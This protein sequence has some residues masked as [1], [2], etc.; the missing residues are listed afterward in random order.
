MRKAVLSLLLFASPVAAQFGPKQTLFRDRVQSWAGTLDVHGVGSGTV[1]GPGGSTI[2]YTTDQHVSGT[3]GPLV[4]NTLLMDWEGPLDGTITISETSTITAAC[5]ITN[6]LTASTSADVDYLGQPLIFHLSFDIGSDTWSLWPSDQYVN[7]NEHSVQ[8]CGGVISTSDATVP[9]A[10]MPINFSEGFPFPATGFDLTGVS[11]VICDGCGNANSNLVTYTFTY[12]L[13]ATTYPCNY[14]LSAPSGAFSSLA[15]SGSVSVDTGPSCP[16]EVTLPA[17]WV[18][19]TSPLTGAGPGT[20]DYTVEANSGPDRS[21]TMDIGGVT[22][23]IDQGGPGY[24]TVTPC[25]VLDTRNPDG[26]LGG[27]ALQPHATRTFDVAASPCGIPA[28]AEAVSVVLTVTQGTAPGNLVIY[29]GD[30]AKPTANAISYPAGKTRANNGVF[31][32]ASDGSETIKVYTNSSG[33]V[34]FILDVNGYFQ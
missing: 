19:V 1:S 32:L 2:T 20:V 9:M 3:L 6:T 27:P 16:W 33:T 34:H 17:F 31:R 21:T 14:S 10:F 25:R 18:N 24:F 7:G 5:T 4:F 28:T 13:T 29:P 23:T 12:D 30:V 8:D 26:P 15:S 22:F 11:Q